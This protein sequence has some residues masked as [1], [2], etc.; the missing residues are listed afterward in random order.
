MTETIYPRLKI[1]ANRGSVNFVFVTFNIVFQRSQT[2]YWIQ[3]K[4]CIVLIYFHTYLYN[5]LKKM[6]FSYK[7][8]I[9]K[10]IIQTDE[11]KI[12][13]YKCIKN[14][15]KKQQTAI[16]FSYTNGSLTTTQTEGVKHVS[17]SQDRPSSYFAD[18]Y[19]RIT[20]KELYEMKKIH[21]VWMLNR[22]NN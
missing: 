15:K 1:D 7:N 19:C 9:L 20:N 11:L 22:C 3:L 13:L 17:Q 10:N 5:N 21:H 14:I 8:L 6:H 16:Y 4:L 2:F 12:Y 18:W